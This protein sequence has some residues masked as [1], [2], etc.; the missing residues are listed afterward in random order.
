MTRKLPLNDSQGR[1]EIRL[2]SLSSL[3][4]AACIRIPVFLRLISH[5][6]ITAELH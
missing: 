1:G 3:H 5:R 6:Y 4:K 2:L